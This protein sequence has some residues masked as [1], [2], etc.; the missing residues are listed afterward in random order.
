M[1]FTRRAFSLCGLA[2][3][4]APAFG[5]SQP[6]SR[7]LLG[8]VGCYTTG[9]GPPQLGIHPD[10]LGIY[11]FRLDT[12]TG[13]LSDL[14]LAATCLSPTNLIL[15]PH[16]GT[17]YAGQGGSLP[18]GKSSTWRAYRVEGRRLR[19]LNSVA[20]GGT[21]PTHGVVNR[22][23]HFLIS[24]NF[25]SNEVT[26]F[27]IFRDGSLGEPTARIV[28]SS[29]D[30]APPPPPGSPLPPMAAVCHTTARTALDDCR[31]KPHIALLSHSERWLVVA[32]IATDAIAVYR[33]NSRTGTLELHHLANGQAGGGPRHLVWSPDGRFL[34]SSDE[35]GA[36]V[37]LWSWD[38]TTGKAL[39]IE[40][41]TTIPAGHIGQV[42]TAH[43]AI[44]PSGRSLWV[45]N[46][47]SETIA[48]F[49]VDP[50]SGRLAAA[51]H[52]PTGGLH[53]WCFDLDRTGRW[54]VAGNISNDLLLSYQVD[55]VSARLSPSQ[56]TLSASFPTCV[57][58]WG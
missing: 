43:I 31:T 6:H 17:L 5:L 56:S 20:A 14:Q 34:Y 54:L 45:S 8:F 23:G 11:S 28:T 55:A 22:R 29:S 33:F 26:V 46:R 44:H 39:H 4:T 18:S 48:C 47:G 35:H 49:R 57:R 37:S 52:A 1:Q 9:Q 30:A 40:A 36:T 19:P 53:C 21:G 12:L 41:L 15:A 38:E 27:E 13:M 25:S 32:E 3:S 16:L 42:T 50:R 24:T 10:A 2:A 58:I 51:G 7:T